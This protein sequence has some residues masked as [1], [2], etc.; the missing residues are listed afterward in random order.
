MVFQTLNKLKWTGK[1]E[2]CKIVIRHRGAPEDRKE[3]PGSRI[4]QVKKSY[5]YY[6]DGDRENF[7]P[8]HRV[9]LITVGGEVLWKR[10]TKKG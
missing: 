4:T 10:N 8:L 6:K 9:L 7:I 1:L 2:K 5:F 3:I